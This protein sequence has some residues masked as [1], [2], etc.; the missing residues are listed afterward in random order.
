MESGLESHVDFI[1]QMMRVYGRMLVVIWYRFT[2][3]FEWLRG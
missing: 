2:F 1:L 3:I